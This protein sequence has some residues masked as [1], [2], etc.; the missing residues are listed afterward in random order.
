M[1]IRT[2]ALLAAGSMLASGVTAQFGP[3]EGA[4]KIKR[5][6][7]Q[8]ADEMEQIDRLLL[9]TGTGKAAAGE[10]GAAIG[11]NI[12]RIDELL[13]QTT[14]SQ[15]SVVRG[16]DDLIEELDKMRANGC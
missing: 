9:Q 8:V 10:A 16:I 14:Q 2:L 4:E 6:V 1:D 7:K 11:R 12:E 5:I 3:D 15:T 13:D